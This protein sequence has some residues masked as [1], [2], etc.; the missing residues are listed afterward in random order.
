MGK[1]LKLSSKIMLSI[2]ALSIMC[3]VAVFFAVNTYVRSMIVEYVQDIHY[4][5]N[6]I[7]ADEVNDWIDQFRHK[8]DGMSLALS[9]IPRE[10]K[11]DVASF[12]VE[13]HDEITIVWIAFPDGT[14]ETSL[15]PEEI[16]PGWYLYNRPWYVTAMEARDRTLAGVP[17][18][19]AA[20][21]EWIVP[22]SRYVDLGDTYLVTAF[23]VHLEAVFDMV[24]NFEAVGGGHVFLISSDGRFIAHPNPMYMPTDNLQNVQD[25]LV[26]QSILPNILAGESFVP[27]TYP[28]GQAFYLLSQPLSSADWIMVSAIPA[29][30]LDSS[31]DNAVN[32]IMITAAVALLILAFVGLAYVSKLLEAAFARTVTEFR[33]SS[34]ALARGE[35]L[36]INSDG[37]DSFG[38]DG[39]T[40]EFDQ[41]LRIMA[42]VME[43]LSQF[44]HELGVN[45]DIDYRVDA[46]KYTGSFKEVIQ[47]INGFA[48]KFVETI[49]QVIKQK[50]QIEVSD[51]NSQAKSKFLASMSH[52][53][54]TPMNAILGITEIQLRKSDL[55]SDVRE[56]F[57]KIYVSGDML[58]GIINDILDLSK[59]ESGKMELVSEKYEVASTIN[60]TIVLNLMRIEDRPIEFE[61]FVDETMPAYMYGDELRIKQIFNNILSNAFKYTNEGKVT[62]SVD[63]MADVYSIGKA[64][65]RIIVSDTGQGMTQ[66][67]IDSLFD[68]Y[69]RFNLSENQFIE[70]TGLGM[71]I[72]NNLVDLMGG[73]IDVVSE[74]GVGT[75]FTVYIPQ[76][77]AGNDKIGKETA[78]AFG[79][80]HTSSRVQM[81]RVKITQEP[82]P[83]GKILI[84]DD[85]EMNIYVARGLMAPY[86]MQID[87]AESGFIALDKVAKGNEY[88]IIFMDHMMPQMDGL[89]TTRRLRQMGY[90]RPI[91][92]L[93]ANAVVRQANLFL[94]NGFD[95]FL[96]KPIDIRQLNLVLNRLVRDVQPP[97]VIEQAR[98][99]AAA[100][101]DD[102]KNI[103]PYGPT[104]GVYD[105][106]Y[107]EF[108][109]SQRNFVTDLNAALE[110]N[111]IKQAYFLAHTIKG[112]AG[113]IGENN[114]V[115]IAGKAEASFR[116]GSVPAEI[117][118]Q[119][120]AEAQRV[121]AMI[122]DKLSG[123]V[124]NARD[125]ALALNKEKAAEVFDKLAALLEADSFDALELC[126]EVAEIPETEELIRQVEDIE[127]ALALKTLVKL[128]ET[129]GV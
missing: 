108:E 80:F 52:E 5:Q 12:F 40:K 105:I 25:S 92:A 50:E 1:K 122:E 47:S 87:S 38:L 11:S 6:A 70:G 110:A 16:M 127:F 106:L 69:A 30:V 98:R 4:S 22:I 118:K 112:L 101:K 46:A 66:E 124:K 33:A 117:V 8:L 114:L 79:K 10:Y 59:I 64:T 36:K 75:V 62:M 31:I 121:L 61:V 115:E 95:D 126:A 14:W 26:Y 28:D 19:A 71:N 63:A 53:I 39:I 27:L 20:T 58:L 81:K 76:T 68:A 129:L 43:D 128:R 67:Q 37:D 123:S 73:R 99:Q 83:Y 82:M 60:D 88:D 84:V 86:G 45:G 29:A 111:N 94:K 65:L 48:D 35:G 96:S 103:S 109:R 93:T 56:S 78:D 3:L 23:I 34:A 44:S 77:V 41:N 90:D 113:L 116:N 100:D 13:S 2:T 9:H 24:A 15:N 102:G 54:R 97:E 57:E 120:V 7:K 85:V 72:T 32:V 107:K 55:E 104:H 51:A 17:N 91:V 49:N 18:F 21:H 89:E 119:L 125:V 74:L 42:D